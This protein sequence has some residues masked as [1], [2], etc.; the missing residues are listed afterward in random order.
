MLLSVLDLSFVTTATP[1]CAA[2]ANT[3]D[4]AI[5]ADRLGF[6]RYWV[7][8]HH[9]LPSVASG[10][11]EIV[12]GRIAAATSRIRVGSGG[13][14]LPNHAP[15]LVAERFK[16]LEA[17]FPGRIDLGLGRAPGTDR[18]TS[19][20]LRR[21][22]IDKN[23]DDDFLERF[24]ELLGW[25]R[26]FPEGH[27]FHPIKVM[28][29]DVPVPPLWLLGSSDY[30]AELA[31]ATGH[32]FAFAHHFASVDAEDVMHR[33]RDAFRPSA[34][35]QKPHAI[36]ATAAVVADTDAEAEHL[37]LTIDLNYVRR[38]HGIYG[39]LAS[40]S[41]VFVTSFTPAEEAARRAN[42]A[43]LFVGSPTRVFDLLSAFAEIHRR[44]RAHDHH[45]HLRPRGAPAVVR[46]AGG[47]V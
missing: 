42:R 24:Q 11:P 44:R 3:L 17:F 33:Y 26:G 16:V 2:L 15:L 6:H 8:E 18:L 10:S 1:P 32:G 36:L 14:M 19:W 20:A 34:A 9:S 45:R 12:I 7:A 46:A 35:L 23:P 13:V 28:P 25:A 22:E 29:E 21:R 47:G 40:P 4:L 27:P 5:L 31:A 39:P 43:R 30:S 38:S 37:A 41:E